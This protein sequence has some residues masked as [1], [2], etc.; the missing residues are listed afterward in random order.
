MKDVPP[1][2][3]G[4]DLVQRDKK[5]M[6]TSTKTSEL[7]AER[8][9]GAL[10][11]DV[12]GN[13]YVDFTSGI[14]V[15]N[16]GHCHP[17]VVKAITEQANR[18]MHFAGTDFYYDIQVSLAERL[19]EV[20]PGDFA[21]K[22][23]YT[24]SGAE[25]VE[26]A[27]KVARWSSE[28]GR[29]IAFIGAFHG[30]TMGA[31]SLTASKLQH[32]ERFFPTMPGV[33]HVP[34]AYC[35]RCP[36]KLEY[37]GCGI[38]CADAIQELYLDKFVPPGDVAGLFFEPVQGEGGYVVPPPE[39]PK[40]V[41]EICK[42][43]GIL[44]IDDDV[45][46]GF[47]RT[48]KMFGI[49]HFDIVPDILCIAKGMGS[50]IPVGA[51]IFNSELDFGVQGAHSNTYGGNLIACNATI[52]TL[53]VI[54][55]ENLTERAEKLGSHMRKRLDEMKEE[56]PIMGD[57]RGLGLMQATEF[58]TDPETKSPAPEPRN[59][60]VEE[61][62]KNGVILL[63]CGA[64]GVRYIPPLNIEEEYLDNGLDIIQRIIKEAG[65]II[66]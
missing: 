18:L 44:F 49:E 37:P 58:V 59:Y 63:P 40:K 45:Q 28:K 9:E 4:K 15:V 16:T 39:F 51:A 25:S 43:N 64:S 41:H 35:Y 62:F 56:N 11:W 30:R 53:D 54:E 32:Q 24:N 20:T 52:A 46:A 31:L 65:D 13:L 34:Y 21:K 19:A 48:G 66:R 29:F 1:G 57:N 60:V 7:V 22:V 42:D 6:A 8:A 36:Y 23:F 17:T 2:D 47:G 14:G 3:R 12:D 5:I 61:S 27:I 55:K 26:A 10:V 33:D 50:G 38:W